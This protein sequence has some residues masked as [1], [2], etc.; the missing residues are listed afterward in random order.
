MDSAVLYWFRAKD[1]PWEEV[2][3]PKRKISLTHN[4][5]ELGKRPSVDPCPGELRDVRG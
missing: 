3:E 1:W 4:Y 5:M 2:M